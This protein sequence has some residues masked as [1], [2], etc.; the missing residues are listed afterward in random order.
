M[1]KQVIAS[2]IV[3]D[4]VVFIS[5]S[6][7]GQ[8]EKFSVFFPWFLGIDLLKHLKIS[9]YLLYQGLLPTQRLA[10]VLAVTF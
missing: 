8:I 5:E 7:V 9:P 1:L 6:S 10:E 2:P 3:L 4:L